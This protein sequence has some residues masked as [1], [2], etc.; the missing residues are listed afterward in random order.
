MLSA[1]GALSQFDND[2]GDISRGLKSF[3]NYSDTFTYLVSRYEDVYDHKAIH[4]IIFMEHLKQLQIHC[5]LFLLM[6]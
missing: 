6:I 1:F 2:G 4:L 3:L 5:R